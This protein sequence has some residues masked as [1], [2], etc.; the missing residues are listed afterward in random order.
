MRGRDLFGST[1]AAGPSCLACEVEG[2]WRLLLSWDPRRHLG[3]DIY[4]GIVSLLGGNGV[5][6]L[7]RFG[8]EASFC[9]RRFYPSSRRVAEP[10]E[11]TSGGASRSHLQ[12]RG[13]DGRMDFPSHCPGLGGGGDMRHDGRRQTTAADDGGGRRR[14]Q[15]TAE[16][17]GGDHRPQPHLPPPPPPPLLIAHRVAEQPTPHIKSICNGYLFRGN[18]RGDPY[19]MRR[20]RRR[21]TAVEDSGGGIY[22]IES[23]TVIICC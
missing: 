2:V 3:T 21:T 15:T 17:S 11:D 14:R 9:R 22:E 20:K 8:G 10:S 4:L 6:I 23:T 5:S 12:R 16:D 19:H 13:A 1:R 7:L 18:P